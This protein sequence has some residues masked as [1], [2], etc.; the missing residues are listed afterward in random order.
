MLAMA[1]PVEV[2][3][4]SSNVMTVCERAETIGM[5]MRAKKASGSG[6]NL[7]FIIKHPFAFHI[8]G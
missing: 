1:S 3:E 4:R 7:F 5:L 2:T 6:H 8:E